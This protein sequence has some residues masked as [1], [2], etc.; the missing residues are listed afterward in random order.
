MLGA[1]DHG[2]ANLTALLRRRG[3]LDDTIILFSTA[4]SDTNSD[5]VIVFFDDNGVVEEVASRFDRERP[6]W[7][8][9]WGDD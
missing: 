8:F 1:L 3:M 4:R 7:G 5:R 9:P 2:V 6:R